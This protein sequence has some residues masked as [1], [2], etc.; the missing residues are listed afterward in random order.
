MADIDYASFVNP[1]IGT[2]SSYA[3]SSGNTLPIVAQPLPMVSIT[4]DMSTYGNSWVYTYGSCSGPSCQNP[5][6]P[7][8]SGFRFTRQP[9]PWINDY[10][11]IDLMPLPPSFSGVPTRDNVQSKKYGA[12]DHRN[13]QAHPYLY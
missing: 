6:T 8:I 7:P 10:G 11:D 5:A 4:P 13:E 12:F 2:D 9:S 1:L 3:F